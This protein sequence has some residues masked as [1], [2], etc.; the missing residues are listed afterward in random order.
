[1]GLIGRMHRVRGVTLGPRRWS[2][3]LQ[4]GLVI[5]GAAEKPGRG[6]GRKGRGRVEG[7]V[8]E[9]GER[10]EGEE[11]EREKG[12]KGEE[13]EGEEGGEERRGEGKEG[14]KF[15]KGRK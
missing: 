10:E 8:G 6:K 11:G 9:E 12:E 1:M 13:R 5:R 7:E 15:K 3:R 2:N 14:E 4:E